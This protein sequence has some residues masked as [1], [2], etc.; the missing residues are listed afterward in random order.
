MKI[1]MN[2]SRLLAVCIAT[3][4]AALEPA[5]TRPANAP[6]VASEPA[7][8]ILIQ[9]ATILTVSHGNIEHGSILIRDGKIAEVGSSIKAPKDAQVI[10]AVF[11]LPLAKSVANAVR[12]VFDSKVFL[13]SSEPA[14]H[15]L[16]GPRLA[17]LVA[18]QHAGAG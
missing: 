15:R 18:K 10:D 13:E 7:P 1:S 16:G 5:P 9:N 3:L 14:G 8:V 4:L 11:Q 6:A 17:I 2:S 12:G